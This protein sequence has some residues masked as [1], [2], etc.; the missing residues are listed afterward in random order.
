MIDTDEEPEIDLA[1]IPEATSSDTSNG[2]SKR[3][4]QS[5]GQHDTSKRSK[6]ETNIPGDPGADDK[7]LRLATRYEGFSI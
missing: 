7:K 4:R 3:R 1:N 2:H 6:T 5:N